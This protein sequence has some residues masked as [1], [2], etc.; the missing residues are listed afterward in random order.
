VCRVVLSYGH[1]E[2]AALAERLKADLEAPG[3]AT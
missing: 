1:D 3:L 2:H